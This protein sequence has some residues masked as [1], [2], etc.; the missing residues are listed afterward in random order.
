MEPSPSR[1]RGREWLRSREALQGGECLFRIEELA[2]TWTISCWLIA[3]DGRS[4][5]EGI[6]GG[7]EIVGYPRKE[8][9][10]LH[11]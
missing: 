5:L 6:A 3:D 4:I 11:R 10:I 7:M 9:N 8:E 2:T 1:N